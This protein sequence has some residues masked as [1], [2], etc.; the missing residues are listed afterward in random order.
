MDG[1]LFLVKE[2]SSFLEVTGEGLYLGLE[3]GLFDEGGGGVGGF[4]GLVVGQELGILLIDSIFF[5]FHFMDF[6]IHGCQ[7]LISF[8]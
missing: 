1:G 3:L 2:E 4:Q 6:F 5:H 8:S 7:L